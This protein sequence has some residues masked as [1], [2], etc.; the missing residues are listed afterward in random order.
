[1][2]LEIRF[3]RLHLLV[4]LV[5]RSRIQPSFPHQRRRVLRC[6]GSL[7][8]HQLVIKLVSDLA[9]LRMFVCVRFFVLFVHFRQEVLR[10]ILQ[11]K[12]LLL[13]KLRSVLILIH[14]RPIG[15]FRH[16]E[17][18]TLPMVRALRTIE[19]GHM[20]EQYYLFA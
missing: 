13:V 7:S 4:H 20:L 9:E 17:E 3:H 12:H 18:Q 5:D 6:I 10:I 15:V 2:N 11:T 14:G 16:R 1:M 8:I 19:R